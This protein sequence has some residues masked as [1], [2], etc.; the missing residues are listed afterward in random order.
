MRRREQEV[1]Q[2]CDELWSVCGELKN[3]T[4]EAI[5]SRLELLGKSRGSPNEIYR[6]RKTWVES[7]HI[8]QVSLNASDDPI[9]RAARIVHEQIRAEA[10]ARIAQSLAEFSNKEILLKNALEAAKENS[11][12]L[13]EE[14]TALQEILKKSESLKSQA[15]IQLKESKTK[16]GQLE[17]E[18]S[19]SAMQAEIM[20]KNHEKLLTELKQSH[21]N[22]LNSIN[23]GFDHFKKQTKERISE[24]EAR[25][26]KLG[27]EFSCDLNDLKLKN[28]N[29]EIVLTQKE[30]TLK[31]LIEQISLQ[32]KISSEQEE[33]LS[34]LS[35]ILERT[36]NQCEK[37]RAD[38]LAKS[39]IL[40]MIEEK[41]RKLT[42]EIKLAASRL[43]RMRLISGHLKNS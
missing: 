3:L 16:C 5:R 4:G 39:K 1:W 26:R 36:N 18:L 34:S 13:L 24:L 29:L 37:L 17:H 28:F 14:F 33:K 40:S 11:K 38:A 42:N 41:N 23:N 2:A 21:I 12:N 19:K 35:S 25:E 10:D 7:R 32:K 20:T 22:E 8:E 31:G 30:E 9:S 43:S 15:E 6:Y 27:Q